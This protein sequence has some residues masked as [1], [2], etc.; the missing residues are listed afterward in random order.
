MPV[1]EGMRSSAATRL[2]AS[3]E[4]AEETRPSLTAVPGGLRPAAADPELDL[5]LREELGALPTTTLGPVAS[6]GWA[7]VGV[8]LLVSLTLFFVYTPA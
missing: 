2:E 6:L 1:A 7:M 3:P 4:R 5:V 8:A